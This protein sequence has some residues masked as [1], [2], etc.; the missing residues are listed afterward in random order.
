MAKSVD[1]IKKNILA[2]EIGSSAIKIAVGE[3]SKGILTVKKAVSTPLPENVYSDGDI[4]NMDVMKN[5]IISILNDNNIKSKQCFCT[6]KSSRILTR[7]VTVPGQNKEN[8]NDIAK[9]EVEQYMPIDMD[10]YVVQSVVVRE[11]FIDNKPFAEMLVTAVPKTLIEQMHQLIEQVG[12]NP[13]VLDTHANAFS[14]LIEKQEKINGHVY[15]KKDT[16]AFVDFGNESISINIFS[17][18]KY[19]FHRIL[20]GGGQMLDSALAST[21]GISQETAKYKKVNTPNIYLEM[22]EAS[23]EAIMVKVIKTS[24]EK[25]LVEINKIFRYYNTRTTGAENN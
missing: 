7:E 6:I 23:E 20:N 8:L 18:G 24:I 5:T 1:K 4:M 12:L 22:D 16:V 3:I 11:M 15:H 9:Y 25:W 21:L 10:H 19:R 17:D 14:K 2:M 13:V